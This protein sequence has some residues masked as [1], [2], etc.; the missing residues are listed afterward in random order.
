V[1]ACRF[2]SADGKQLEPVAGLLNHGNV[3]RSLL[4]YQ[5]KDED[6]F[7]D[8]EDSRNHVIVSS[9]LLALY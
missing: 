7:L 5:H 3:R 4:G 8:R 9:G 2:R 1:S 6:A